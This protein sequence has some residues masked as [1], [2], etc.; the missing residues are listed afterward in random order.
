MRYYAYMALKSKGDSA[1]IAEVQNRLKKDS[2]NVGYFSGYLIHNMPLG[3]HV[4]LHAALD[5][6]YST[7]DLLII[8]K[9]G[10][11]YFRTKDDTIF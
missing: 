1:V 8:E 6:G 10:L 3:N 4:T 5:A 9:D 7:E 11:Q 2:A